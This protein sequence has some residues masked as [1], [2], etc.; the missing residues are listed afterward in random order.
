MTVTEPYAMEVILKYEMHLVCEITVTK[1]I[2]HNITYNVMSVTLQ[3][4]MDLTL[5]Y[6]MDVS[7]YLRNKFKTTIQTF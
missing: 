7:L 5:Y 3:Y 2:Y 1:R 6:V 4:V